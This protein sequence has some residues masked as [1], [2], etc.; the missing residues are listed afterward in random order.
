M[1]RF[2]LD[3]RTA[4]NHF[5]GIGRYVSNLARA[6]AKHLEAD[7]QLVLLRNDTAVSRWQLPPPSRQ[8]VYVNTAVS[9]FGMAQQW[10]L[11]HLLR[12]QNARSY[13]SPYYLMPYRPGVPTVL[14]LHDLIPQHFPELVSVRARLLF[15]LFTKLALYT[16]THTLT[17]SEATRRDVLA[18]YNVD[19][20]RITTIPH[21]PDL[22]FRPQPESELQRIRDKFSLPEQYLLYLGINKPHKNLVRL[23]QAWQTV[24]T[25][26]PST[27]PLIIAGAWDPRYPQAKET[28]AAILPETA[29]RFLGPVENADLPGLYSGALLFVFPSLYEGFG[30]PVVEA[31]ACGTA[32]LCSQ[33]SSLPEVG[34]DAVAYFDP[35]NLADIANSINRMLDDDSIRHK[36]QTRGLAQA[37]KFTW[38]K[39]AMTTLQCYRQLA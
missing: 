31:M 15:R 28:A 20:A 6:M 7:E 12:Q 9:P 1:K 21:A 37:A 39:T 8:V 38:Q 35:L 3:A 18:A 33:T 17:V 25:K 34:G 36:M 23:L 14:T 32:V 27:P 4:I 10:R 24:L 22:Q 13:H 5:P 30:L 26:R 11:P 29:V 19:P 16:A 2:V